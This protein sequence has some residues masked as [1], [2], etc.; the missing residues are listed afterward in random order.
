MAAK[1]MIMIKSLE[2]NGC[3]VVAVLPLNFPGGKLT[4]NIQGS[5]HSNQTS[6]EKSLEREQ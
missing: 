3:G 5:K 6:T 4:K 2:G 1:L